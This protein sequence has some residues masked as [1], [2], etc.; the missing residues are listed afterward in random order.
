MRMPG[1]DGLKLQEE[2]H[3]TLP[4]LSM[5][6]IT[7]HGTVPMSVEAMKGGAVDPP[8]PPFHSLIFYAF[9]QAT[10]LLDQSTITPIDTGATGI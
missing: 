10:I 9:G 1:F 2:L 3:K 6:F 7:G 8:A 4:H 5:V